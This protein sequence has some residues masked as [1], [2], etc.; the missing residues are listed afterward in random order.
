MNLLKII[1]EY[2][3]RRPGIKKTVGVILILIGLAALIT[4]LTPGSWLIIIG[5]ELL[6][7]RILL[8]DR[9]TPSEIKRT[10]ITMIGRC[11]RFLTGLKFWKKKTT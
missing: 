9:L 1:K 4:P 6:G 7:A 10:L 3:D 5:M 11:L 8:S 2:L